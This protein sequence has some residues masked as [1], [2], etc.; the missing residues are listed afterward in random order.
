[1]ADRAV[2]A[3]PEHLKLSSKLVEFWRLR[4]QSD[5]GAEPWYYDLAAQLLHEGVMHHSLLSTPP[6]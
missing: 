6:G 4:R 2:I 3:A 1:M 5:R